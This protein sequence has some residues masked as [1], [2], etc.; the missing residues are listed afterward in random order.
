MK[1]FQE[2]DNMLVGEF[3]FSHF[4]HALAFVN[5]VGN[6]AEI[7]QHHPDISLYNYKYVRVSTTTH[8]LWNTL[9]EKDY[10]LAERIERGYKP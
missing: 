10:T 2:K 6:I 9:T 1:Y 5:L 8:D 4:W 3:E 7:S